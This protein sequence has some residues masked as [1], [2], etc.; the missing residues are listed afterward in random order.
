MPTKAI[1]ERFL[2]LHS[3]VKKGLYPNATT[4]AGRFETSPKTAQ[5][6]IDFMQ[7]RLCAP[8][9]YVRSRRGY[10]YEDNAYELPGS[11]LT[12]DDL[13][14]LLL[15]FRLASTIPDSTMKTRMKAFLN[16]VLSQYTHEIPMGLDRL[17]EKVSVKNIEYSRTSDRIFQQVL[18]ALLQSRPIRIEYYSPHDDRRTLRDVL[19]LHLLS[20]MGTWHLIAHCTLRSD[21]RDF[22]LS[23]IQT[24]EPSE[25]KIK[26][27]VSPDSLKEYIRRNFGILNSADTFEVCIRFSPN[28][29]PWISEQVWHT[30]Q[31]ATQGSDGS[32]LLTFPVADFREIRREILKYGSD[33]EVISPE[34]L[35]DEVKKEIRKMG[36][37]Y[38]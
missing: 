17:S 22:A 8:L 25:R 26:V 10:A 15:S 38:G 23:R 4:M 33:A 7:D 31:V 18:E 34:A 2:W 5:R 21:L 12:A 3:Q 27:P 11:W 30:G 29:A 32:L 28:I 13:T 6:D 16:Q 35:R 1:Y 37:V 36:A 9:V 20:Y 24:I 14:S 19:P